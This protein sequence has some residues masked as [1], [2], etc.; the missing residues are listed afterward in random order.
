[1]KIQSSNPSADIHLKFQ[2]KKPGMIFLYSLLSGFFLLSCGPSKSSEYNHFM[3]L[4]QGTTYHI[5]Y[6]GAEN[7]KPQ[8][9]SLLAEFDTSLS[10]YNKESLITAINENRSDSADRFLTYCVE[11]AL[12]ICQASNGA[13]DITIGPLANSWGFGF[14]NKETITPEKIDSLLPFV[15]CDKVSIVGNRII[16]ASPEVILNVNAIAQGYAVDVVCEWLESKKVSNYMVE[17]GGEVKVKG[18]NPHQSEWKVGI[19]EPIDDS[20]NVN[21][22]IH[23]VVRISEHAMATSGNYRKFY[24]ENGVKYSHTLDPKTGYPVKHNL[25]SA[26]V[27]AK[28]CIEADAYATAFMVVGLEK[29]LEILKLHPELEAYFIYAD[30]NGT[31][32]TYYTQGMKEHL[33]PDENQ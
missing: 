28:T 8:I 14:K 27:L 22:D 3:G 13:F 11:Q 32:Q 18:L 23:E 24:V 4:T 17:I 9:D 6:K 15:G 29:A 20:L 5:T 19:N 12:L 33:T 30:P 2:D 21:Q 1:M 16:K 7:Y 25:L 31:F 26:S 10:T